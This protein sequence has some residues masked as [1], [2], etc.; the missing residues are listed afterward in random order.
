MRGICGLRL[1]RLHRNRGRLIELEIELGFGRNLDLLALGRA[2][3]DAARSCSRSRSDC[4][5]LSAAKQAAKDRSDDCPA[6]Y[7]LFRVFCARLA[8]LGIRAADEG[9][10]LALIFQFHQFK[11]KFALPGHF[12]GRTRAREANVD[13]DAFWH[14]YVI[15]N[16]DWRIERRFENLARLIHG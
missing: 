10:R 12:S 15:P 9:K 3:I 4:S 14:N 6:A 7:F 2:L 16:H 5:T 13:I 11:A 1:H 8:D